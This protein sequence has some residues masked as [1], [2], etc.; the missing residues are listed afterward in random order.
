MV[1]IFSEKANGSVV[2][3]HQ[4]LIG[5]TAMAATS[6]LRVAIQILI[7]PIIGRLLGPQAYGQVALVSPFVFFAMM[8]AESG[9]GACIVNANEVT[10]EL[11]GTV[12]CFSAGLSTLIILLF[13]IFAYPAGMVMHEPMFPFLLISMSSILLLAAFAIVPTALLLRAKRYDFVA[14]SDVA[15]SVGSIVGVGIGIW[16]GWGVWSLVVQQITLWTAK[17]LVLVIAAHWRPTFVFRRNVL[18]EHMAFGSRLTGSNILSFVARNI[19]NVLIGTFMGAQT[20]G[21]Y[22]LAFQIVGLPSMVLSDLVYFTV[23]TNTSEARRKNEFTLDF[24]LKILR[25]SLI[26][27]A[28][29][30]IGLAVT[31]SISV[32]LLLGDKW[33]PTSNLVVLL[34]PLGLQQIITAMTTGVIMG[35]GRSDLILKLNVISSSLTVAAIIAG[36]FISS[37]VVAIGVSLAAVATSYLHLKAVAYEGKLPLRIIGKAMF[38]PFLASIV[39]GTVVYILQS[40]V[41]FKWPL[42]VQLPLSI[43]MGIVSYGTILFCFFHDSLSADIT[44]VR[45]AFLARREAK[46]NLS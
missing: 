12:L 7:L 44:M 19:D 30:I 20:L 33:E 4:S 45:A 28:P 14:L 11:E 18:N 10:K 22:A 16:L 41:P 36:V 32:P 2:K 15:S 5:T 3:K 13:A 40:I 9:F 42:I 26:I 27:G 38:A 21:Y 46:G 37:S 17:V 31:A 6:V 35:L 8:L 29:T 39:M 34:A 25:G 1:A 24:I 43:G 23:L